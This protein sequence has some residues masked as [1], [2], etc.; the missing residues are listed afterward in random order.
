MIN[1]QQLAALSDG[2]KRYVTLET[3]VRLLDGAIAVSTIKNKFYNTGALG[4]EQGVHHMK[5]PGNKMGR[6]MIDF[7]V[8]LEALGLK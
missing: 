4:P 1:P 6:L 2:E 3:A 7:P 8:F 5:L